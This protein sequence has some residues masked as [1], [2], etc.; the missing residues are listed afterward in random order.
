MPSISAVREHRTRRHADRILDEFAD[1]F[2]EKDFFPEGGDE[3]LFA[4]LTR[5]PD[6]PADTQI[7]VL[8]DDGDVAGYLKGNDENIALYAVV[9][10]LQDDGTYSTTDD[11]ARPGPESLFQ[12]ILNQLPASSSLGLGGDFHGSNSI[13]GRIV[14][15]REQL[16]GMARSERGL[17][18]DALLADGR[19]VKS[20]SRTGQPNPFL[21]LWTL[22][23]ASRL[24]VLAKLHEA[25]PELPS[26]RLAD[27]LRAVPMTDGQQSEF[28]QSGVIPAEHAAALTTSQEEYARYR[29]IDGILNTRTYDAQTDALARRLIR[30]LLKF[31]L[32]REL[33]IHERAQGSYEPA[34]PDDTRLVLRHGDGGIYWVQRLDSGEIRS[35]GLTT[36]S[37]YLAVGSLLQP[38][39]RTLCGMQYERDVAGL[40]ATLGN[41][42]V[43]ENGGWFSPEIATNTDNEP[44]PEWF[45]RASAADKQAWKECVLTYT[46][47]MFEAQ[48]PDSPT[49]AVS[50]TGAELRRFARVKLQERLKTD[51]G[52]ELDPDEIRVH[53]PVIRSGGAGSS[54]GLPYI[55]SDHA[56]S[57]PRTVSLTQL[58]LEN[59]AFGD[60]LFLTMARVVDAMGQPINGFG[61]V[62]AY[63]LVRGVDI[64]EAYTA[65]LRTRL[66]NSPEGEWYKERFV[67][68]MQAQMQLDAFEARLAGDYLEDGT[69][70]P[71][72]EDRGYKWVK[73]VLDHPVDDGARPLVEGHRI[74]VGALRIASR[75]KPDDMVILDDCLVFGPAAPLSVSAVVLYTAGAED[76]QC[77]VELNSTEDLRPKLGDSTFQA[78][79]ISQAPLIKR[80]RIRWMLENMWQE[81]KIDVVPRSGNFLEA[82]YEAQA[83]RVIAHVDEKTKSTWEKNWESA[84]SIVS[85]VVDLALGFTPFRVAMPIAAV[86]SLYA[87][88]RAVKNEGGDYQSSALYL[89]AAASFLTAALPA[90]KQTKTKFPTRKPVT[91]IDLKSKAALGASPDGLQLRTDGIYKEVYEQAQQGTASS[92]FIKQEGKTFQVRYDRDNAVWRLIDPRRP[93]A[94]Y[95]VPIRY[96]GG[97]WVYARFGLFGGKPKRVKEE[98]AGTSDGPKRYVVDLTG[99]ED[100]KPFKKEDPHIQEKLT[101]AAKNATDKFEREG[102]GKFHGYDEKDTGR[103][104]F[105]L[106]LTG[107]PGGTGRGP[108]RLQ[109][110]ERVVLDDKGN[111]VKQPGQPGVLKFDKVLPKHKSKH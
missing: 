99:F 62:D 98:S 21:P 79:L 77:F 34:G 76:G 1:R 19:A 37:L 28:L 92:Y 38:H 72:Q 67:Q 53:I 87:L 83:E 13:A 104:I 41:L 109:L 106:D 82:S 80:A 32:D 5:L 84:W 61:A 14:T 16:A 11:G 56:A 17:L 51:F 81:L 4:M 45:K 29:A 18:F 27:L 101:K 15:L 42:A 2:T 97:N 68:V 105:T 107:I 59:V 26:E 73:A 75:T 89:V 94:Y 96:E 33:T 69:S 65:F 74:R 100:A 30:Q 57:L 49:L 103:K 55:G 35:F 91:V 31:V 63:S 110:V 70:P 54:I 90:P 64:G 7:K 111:V 47:A 6:W 12:V 102:G 52:V 46:Q 71:G 58:S 9:L 40:R 24:P 3:L 50:E 23:E 44:A 86:R 85:S 66:L 25:N 22:A 48:V 36:D 8:D 60:I 39:E 95:Q 43:E 20:D 78:H 108:W 10:V 93:D 88:S